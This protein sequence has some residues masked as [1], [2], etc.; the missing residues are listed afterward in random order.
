LSFGSAPLAN[1]RP[2]NKDNPTVADSR[3]AFTLV[4]LLVVIAIIGILIAL[5]LP[6]V[7]AARAAGRRAECSNSLKQIGIALHLYA[8]VWK[9]SLI[10]ATTWVAGVNVSYPRPYWFGEVKDP[11][12]LAPGEERVDRTKGFLMPFME[13]NAQV[14]QCPDFVGVKEVYGKATSGY[15]Y[16]YTYCG[17]WVEYDPMTWAPTKWGIVRKLADFDSTSSTIAFADAAAGADYDDWEGKYLAG[18][19]Y[20]IFNL[21]PPSG[22]YATVHF[23]HQG[24]ANVLFLDGHVRPMRAD[25]N[26]PGPW[27][28][29]AGNQARQRANIADVGPW[30][31]DKEIADKWWHGRGIVEQ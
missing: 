6:A 14:L 24:V 2:G 15:A 9:E 10:P 26:P 21:E 13:R 20:E 19:A 27:A 18:E 30:D 29:P 3:K 12:T 1:L 17:P 5:L 4:E 8:D 11:A 22:Q 7:Q 28:T 31:P 25:T 23:R 16:N